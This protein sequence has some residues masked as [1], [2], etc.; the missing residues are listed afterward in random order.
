[1]AA[2]YTVIETPSRFAAY[3]TRRRH[4]SRFCLRRSPSSQN[5][6]ENSIH[7]LQ[8]IRFSWSCSALRLTRA[9]AC[10]KVYSAFMA[11]PA[12]SYPDYPLFVRCQPGT[13]I[14]LFS[15]PS[16]IYQSYHSL[17]NITLDFTT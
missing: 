6:Q 13:V 7:L 16:L 17:H 1:M 2:P 10:C 3:F 14:F 12:W 8:L 15:F 4:L 5:S 11:A 9:I